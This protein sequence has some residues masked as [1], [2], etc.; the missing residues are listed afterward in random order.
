MAM[1]VAKATRQAEKVSGYKWDIRTAID[2]LNTYQNNIC[3]N[4]QSKEVSMIIREIEAIKQQLQNMM[5]ELDS[6]SSDIKT[7]AQK[8]R[9]QEIARIN[10]AQKAVNN[11]SNKLNA[12]KRER[13]QLNRAYYAAQTDEERQRYINKLAKIHPKITSAQNEYNRCVRELNEAKR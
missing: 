1:D 6:I 4:Y 2:R 3:A 9:N 5:G 7:S 12:L 8:I 13:T 11:A 10:A